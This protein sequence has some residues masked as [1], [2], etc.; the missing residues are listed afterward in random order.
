MTSQTPSTIPTPCC[1]PAARAKSHDGPFSQRETVSDGSERVWRG[2]ADG[3]SPA[4]QES[5]LRR[6]EPFVLL[7]CY[8]RAG[9]LLTWWEAKIGTFVRQVILRLCKR[10]LGCAWSFKHPNHPLKP[11]QSLTLVLSSW[12]KVTRSVYDSMKST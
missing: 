7:L 5:G 11:A 10:Q 8:E 1:L 4:K 2:R 3:R 9:L 6:C 12:R